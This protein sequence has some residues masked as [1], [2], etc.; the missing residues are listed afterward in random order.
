MSDFLGIDIK[1][2]DGCVFRFYQN[3][4]IFKFF[5]DTCM[6]IVMDGQHPK[7]LRHLLV[8]MRMVLRIKYIYPTH[9]HSS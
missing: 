2:L 9:M 8:E 4:F 6:G 7:R 3:E 1:R 5:K